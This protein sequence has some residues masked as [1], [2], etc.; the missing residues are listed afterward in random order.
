MP[1]FE[2]WHPSQQKANNVSNLGG[3][4][5]GKHAAAGTIQLKLL[6]LA[7]A[8]IRLGDPMAAAF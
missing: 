3:S 1:R 2:S 6:G 7:A 8:L 4:C 5:A